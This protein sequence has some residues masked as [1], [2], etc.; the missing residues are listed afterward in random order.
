LNAQA[1]CTSSK[2]GAAI[3]GAALLYGD[4]LITPAISVRSA[5]E[6][7]AHFSP[8]WDS[9]VLPLTCGILASLFLAQPPGSGRLGRW[10]GVVMVV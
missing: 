7:L 6:G 4:G 1:H 5:V 10:F 8:R 3:A 9:A 2:T